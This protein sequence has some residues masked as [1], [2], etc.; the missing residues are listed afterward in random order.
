MQSMTDA[1]QRISVILKHDDEDDQWTVVSVLIDDKGARRVTTL[2][3]FPNRIEAAGMLETIYASLP[4]QKGEG[5]K[6][7]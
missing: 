1:A 2:A 4:I 6:G 5:G 3:R 7:N